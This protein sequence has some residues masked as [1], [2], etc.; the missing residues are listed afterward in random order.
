MSLAFPMNLPSLCGYSMYF[1]FD[2]VLGLSHIT[3]CTCTSIYAWHGYTEPKTCKV[4]CSQAHRNCLWIVLYI[5]HVEIRK[6]KLMA[7]F[8][9]LILTGLYL[10]NIFKF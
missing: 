2:I 1:I 10:Q 7:C 9:R 3:T 5:E 4:A 6:R 8:L